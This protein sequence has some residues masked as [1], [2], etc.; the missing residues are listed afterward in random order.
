M[1]TCVPSGRF[2]IASN[3]TLHYDGHDA[4]SRIFTLS[5]LRQHLRGRW[6][7]FFG[8]SSMRGLVLSLFQQVA[9][10]H[11]P[12]STAAGGSDA[13]I[14]NLTEWFGIPLS[15]VG[16]GWLDVII[17]CD[18]GHVMHART[19]RKSSH[20]S[21]FD[22]PQKDASSSLAPQWA[23]VRSGAIRLTW[24]FAT[25]ARHVA[26]DLFTEL[27]TTP[28]PHYHVLQLGSWDDQ[29]CDLPESSPSMTFSHL[30]PSSARGMT[31]RA[32]QKRTTRS[33]YACA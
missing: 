32:L 24:R 11:A 28:R 14:M 29:V 26:H 9:S 1:L 10:Q 7:Y 2:H 23:T 21:S 18:T 22:I 8:D 3:T 12:H 13:L 5:S 25:L 19:A 4:P 16:I 15:V 6:L 20:G 30:L 31:R 27:R 33:N 17:D